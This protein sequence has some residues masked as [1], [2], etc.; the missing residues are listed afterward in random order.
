MKDK[1]LK[2]ENELLKSLL[3]DLAFAAERVSN[4]YGLDFDG[5]PV[6]WTEWVDLRTA[7]QQAKTK[8][9]IE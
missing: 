2:K 5:K 8:G 1:K 3:Y 4:K 6:D 7:I 9:G